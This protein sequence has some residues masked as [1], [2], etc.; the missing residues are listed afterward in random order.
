MTR[1]Q[2]EMDMKREHRVT[3]RLTDIE[4]SII[5]NAAEQAEMS[6]SEYM[7]TQTMEGNVTARFE[8]V[9]DVDEI[10]K[11]IG[12]FGKIGSNLNQI[13]RY[14]NQGGIIS[15]EMRN[16][17]RKS[18]RDIYEMKYKVMKM[19]GDFRGSN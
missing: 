19:A 17:I 6:I 5:E 4:F 10:K 14:F 16:E 18:L 15:S 12:E 7:R 8:I 13:A 3:I 1:P 11:L 2:K 9:A